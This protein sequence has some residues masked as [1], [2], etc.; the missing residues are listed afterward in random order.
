MLKSGLY[1]K[2]LTESLAKE[3]KESISKKPELI[4]LD[5]TKAADV[6]SQYVQQT[7]KKA[8][9]ELEDGDNLDR[10]LDLTNKVLRIIN[11]DNSIMKPAKELIAVLDTTHQTNDRTIL[12][13]PETSLATSS[14]FTGAIHEPQLYSEL[15]KEILSSDK[16]E[17]LVSFVKWSGLRLIYDELVTFT[18]QGGNLRIIT[19][20][21]MGA[22]DSKA[23]SELVKLNNTEI[24]I[25]YDT[26]RTRLHAKAYLF[27]RNTGFNVAYIGSSNLSNVAI[28][29][30]LEWNLK[31]TAQDQPDTMEKIAAT[32]ESYWQSPEFEIY[33]P[34][35][36][37]KL[38]QAL[39]QQR[40]SDSKA[41]NYQFDIAPYPYQEEILDQ[42][43]ARRLVQNQY[44]NLI[45]AATGTG[46]T[47][48]AAF[49]YQRFCKEAK[50][51]HRL[52]FI[53]HR[54]EILEQSLACFRGVLK[55]PNFGNIYVGNYEEPADISHLF[56][57]IQ[58]F[59]SQQWTLKTSKDYYDY[60]I[61]DE[62]HHAAAP[63]YN[64]LLSYYTPK[65]L[66]GLTATPERL[67]G[68]NITDYFGGEIAAEIRLPQAIDRKLLSPFQY[69]VVSDSVD[70]SKVKWVRGRY[71]K[72]ALAD[73]YLNQT[74]SSR[75]EMIIQALNKY[76]SDLND[77][78]GL[79]FCVSIN[80]AN[81]MAQAFNNYGIASMSLNADSNEAQREQAK[82]KLEKGE[83][84]FIFVVDLYN[85]GVDIPCINTILFLRPTDSL[86]V[87]LQQL[88]R[89]LR[90][91]EGK[92]CLTVLDFVGQA[93]QSY[94]FNSKFSALMEISHRSLT[95]QINSDFPD[96][97]KGCYLKME[98]RAKE[99]I[100][101]NL[102]S[103]FTT[104]K[105]MISLIGT[106]ENDSGLTL[107]LSNFLDYHHLKP[108]DLYHF[109]SLSRLCALAK[110]KE[111]FWDEDEVLLTKAFRKISVIDSQRWL[112]FI[113][114]LFTNLD[115]IDYSTLSLKEK[116]YITML[117]YTI[118]N[119]NW[120]E[121]DF[122][123]AL[124][125]F[126]KIKNNLVLYSE[127]LELLNYDLKHI[128]FIDRPL[129]LENSPL[130]LYC[131]YSRD[132]I[133]TAFDYYA[134]NSMR[135]G[136]LYLKKQDLDI[137]FITLN[138]SE[139][140]YSLTTR[141]Q[142]YSINSHL[143]HWQ[144]QSTTS[145]YSPTA[146]RYLDKESKTHNT[147]LF[148]REYKK[149]NDN[150]APYTLLGKA[151]AQKAEGSNPVNIIYRLNDPIPAKY[152]KTTN[153]LLVN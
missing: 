126:R 49:D 98:Q 125:G 47:C 17:M 62:F 14:L 151:Y 19:T 123:D 103:S 137:F 80:H 106:F 104:S 109:K 122:N 131:N 29:S 30:G 107:N 97:P 120:D 134:T 87:F 95:S 33:T 64:H 94:D 1:E 60:I 57:S 102:K 65:I 88:G 72:Q 15:K 153:Q 4:P 11:D 27:Y 66:L 135:E 148:V 132:Q 116:R 58:T 91:F 59:N 50:G 45:V 145:Q 150:V 38:E 83:V 133:L 41:I 28:S 82:E 9:I 112:K 63:S 136:V 79:G 32:F 81:Y 147:L 34:A 99:V 43:Q 26:K 108:N 42:L 10:Q 13:R 71:D 3:I 113:L 114:N 78:K 25:S 93:N 110:V 143:F 73:L 124:E 52:L 31:I 115:R 46:K 44:R 111:D 37:A 35:D 75:V 36:K 127:L 74:N 20:S 129:D 146:K 141:Y 24:K 7:V 101:N 53:A 92:E 139:K 76:L 16:I 18:S 86:T 67:D 23:V 89:G 54:Q 39:K 40:N 55:D 152:L 12:P 144:S 128:D 118:W 22:T 77:A 6:L 138:K 121:C 84:K 61:V 105:G 100:L 140:D 90:L 85:E 5:K 117:Q 149:D 51:L 68:K 119:K 21:Y 142:D 8:L 48:I 70:L 2:I 130:D 69:F 56:L 96:L